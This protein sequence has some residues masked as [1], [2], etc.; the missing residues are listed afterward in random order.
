MISAMFQVA[1]IMGEPA[2][3][4]HDGEQIYHYQVIDGIQHKTR[5]VDPK[6]AAPI[7]DLQSLEVGIF[8]LEHHTSMPD[9]QARKSGWY[10][11]VIEYDFLDF[12]LYWDSELGQFYGNGDK[13]PFL[14]QEYFLYVSKQ[15]LNL[16]EMTEIDFFVQKDNVVEDKNGLT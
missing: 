2:L 15:P 14:N 9:S 4:H 10:Y 7:F 6:S 12:I 16:S 13:A 11:C 5:I 8:D 3:V 1:Q